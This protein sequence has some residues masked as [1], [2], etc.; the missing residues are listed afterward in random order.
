M[1]LKNK[2]IGGFGGMMAAAAVLGALAGVAAA[3][4][5][6]EANPVVA[7]HKA[8]Y[9]FKMISVKPGAGIV[10]INGKMYYEQ[11]DDCDAWTSE[12]RF[13]MEYQYPERPPVE[14]KSQYASFEAKDHHAFYFNSD[15]MQDGKTVEQL[16][17]AVDI[18][19]DGAAKADY[20]RPAGLSYALPKGYMLPTQQTNETIRRAE[21]GDKFFDAVIF[22][23]TDADGPVDLNTFIGAQLTPAEIKAL[24]DGNKNI[25]ASLLSPRAWHIRVAVFPLKDKD[26]MTPAYEMSMV[27]HDNGVVSHAVVDYGMFKVEQKLVG[28]ERLKPASCGK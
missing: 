16:R 21:A 13:T 10:G 7:L 20:S 15:R 26:A 1:T 23:G 5:A 14:N 4:P 18:G 27:L 2:I 17:G 6:M 19:K 3:P 24:A 9:S 28:L 11:N 8:L 12:H 25:D 22:D